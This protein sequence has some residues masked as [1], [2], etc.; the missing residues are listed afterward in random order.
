[1]V[2][3]RL[4]RDTVANL[5]GALLPVALTF[6]T[7]PP[8]LRLIGAE[9]YG[10]LAL[11]S[12]LLGYFGI[13]EF[14][15]GEASA[16]YIAAHSASSPRKRETV[17][18]TVFTINAALGG[19]T[20]LLLWAVGHYL[21]RVLHISSQM[22]S[23]LLP[24]IP[25]LAAAVPLVT[26]I[27]VLSGALDGRQQ[28]VTSNLLRL[29]GDCTCQVVPLLVAI[30]H[31][32]HLAWLLASAVLAR[33]FSMVLL[34]VACWRQVPL[35][36]L[37]CVDIGHVRE[38]LLFGGWA[39]I[40]G[41][42]YP[43]LK[44]ADQ[45]VI[46]VLRGP[47]AVTY[48]SIPYQCAT[49]LVIVPNSIVRSLFPRLA[50]RSPTDAVDLARRSLSGIVALT[51]PLALV[52]IL[53]LS[54]FLSWWLGPTVARSSH[55]VGE[56]LIVGSWLTGCIA[57][58]GKLLVSQGRPDLVAKVHAAEIVPFFAVLWFAVRVA[59]IEGAALVWVLRSA[60]ETLLLFWLAK[61][62]WRAV[63]SLLTPSAL[64]I[65]AIACAEIA[66]R[67][68]RLLVI[69][70][71]LLLLVT[72]AWALRQIPRVHQRLKVSITSLWNSR[73]PPEVDNASS[74]VSG[75]GR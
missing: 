53:A 13:F 33:G 58:S 35:S 66:R 47:I 31:G 57:L 2:D 46:G 64:L 62:S 41:V 68:T 10:V 15:T 7:I 74:A 28:F 18:W 54:P 61:L 65:T 17:F 6:V 4:H 75:T 71:I 50:M 37:P 27:T 11:A 38:V 3:N 24:A 55:L 72:C 48:Y 51:T 14:G 52:S 36:G 21:L 23:E 34:F 12:V 16:R 1:M 43:L 45:F 22:R 69:L 40:S 60:A 56:L 67:D 63:S 30:F 29:F 19:G 26:T 39:T 44:T 25:W 5:G 32:P 73:R 42:I 70:G 8:Y 59:G 20:G 9:R 49:K